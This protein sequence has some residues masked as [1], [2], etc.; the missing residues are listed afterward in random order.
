[1][2]RISINDPRHDVDAVVAPS[3]RWI[4][5]TTPATVST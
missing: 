2:N 1:M 4:Y 3:A 5:S